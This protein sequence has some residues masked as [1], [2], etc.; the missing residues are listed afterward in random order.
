MQHLKAKKRV[1][2]CVLSIIVLAFS[3]ANII[4]CQNSQAEAEQAITTAE[5]HL[6]ESFTS[7]C[8]AEEAG[9]KVGDLID[10]LN[11]ALNLTLTAHTSVLSGNF[12][13]AA[14]LAS[15]AVDITNEVKNQAEVRRQEA[16]SVSFLQKYETLMVFVITDIIVCIIG[17]LFIHSWKRR[18]FTKKK[19]KLA[20]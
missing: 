20:R 6:N 3:L 8:V 16:V 18:S 10:E 11:A 7:V 9:A 1:F 4:Q 17:V 2:F 19:P 12:A 14:N 5:N 15:N 13:E